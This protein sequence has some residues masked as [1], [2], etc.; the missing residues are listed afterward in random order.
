MTRVSDT[1]KRQ[2]ARALDQA[3]QQ[4]DG[5]RPMRMGWIKSM[6]KALGMSAPDLAHRIGVT[7]AAIYQAERKEREGGVTIR[8]MEKLAEGLGGRFVYAIVPDGNIDDVVRDQARTKAAAII[9]RVS[10]HMALEAQ[11]LPAEQTKRQ[12]EELADD[13][14]RERPADFWQVP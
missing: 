10:A 4:L 11:S 5:F 9:K 3:A 6:R 13:L 8:Q 12:I 14:L 7:K 2:T 1:A